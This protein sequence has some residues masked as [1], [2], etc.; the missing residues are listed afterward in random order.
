MLHH[1]VL[2]RWTDEA[3]EQDQER[4]RTALTALPGQIDAIE[5]Y[6]V[7]VDAG[8][9]PTNCDLSIAATFADEAAWRE[10]QEHPVHQATI[11]EVLVPI[12]AERRA[13]QYTT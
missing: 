2:L 3:T 4:A 9:D 7:G 1:I 11:R 13:I 8:L 5:S 12:V 6:V 10:Y